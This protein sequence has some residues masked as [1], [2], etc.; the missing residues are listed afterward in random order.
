M[1]RV[2]QRFPVRGTTAQALGS[3]DKLTVVEFQNT[4]PARLE[5]CADEALMGGGAGGP[6]RRAGLDAGPGR[7]RNATGGEDPFGRGGDLCLAARRRDRSL[8]P[9]GRRAVRGQQRRQGDA[10]H[11]LP[12]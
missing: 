11:L 9:E 2:I 7:R 12:L 10:D 6:E 4:V 5:G 8:G 1:L 3:T